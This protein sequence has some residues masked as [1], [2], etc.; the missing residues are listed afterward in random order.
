[1]ENRTRFSIGYYL[2]VF[3]TILMIQSLFFSGHEVKEKTYSDFL[4]DVDEGKVEEVVITPEK[5]YGLMKSSEEQ[6]GGKQV[7]E[8]VNP[9]EKSTP[10]RLPGAK[11][12]SHWLDGAEEQM[13][14]QRAEAARHFT[15]IRVD[16]D[17]LVERLQ[18]HDV[19]FEGKIESKF[20][21]NLFFNW[22]IPFGILMLI[23]GFLMR[24]MRGGPNVLAVGQNKAKIVELDPESRVTF[25]DVAG[26]D[27]PIEETRELVQFLKEPARFQQLGGR[28]PRGVLLAGPPGTGK[29]LLAKAV[30]GEAGVPFYSISGSDF[31]EMFVGVGAAR[32]RDLFAEARK[33]AP[34]IIFIDELDAIGKARGQMGP[35]VGGHDERENTLNQLLVEMDGFDARTAVIILAATNRPE[36]LD[37]AL[38]R[39]GRFDRQIICDRPDLRGRE[40]I[41]QVHLRGMPLAD[42]VDP[43]ALAARTPGFVGADIANLCNEAAL[44]AS[45]RGHQ[46]IH[47]E[48]FAE[49]VERIVAGLERKSRIISDKERRIVAYHESGHALIGHF[50]PSA[51]PV[52]KVSIIPRGRAALGYTLQT[53]LEDRYLMSKEELIGRIRVLLGGRA[54]EEVVFGEVSTGASDDL[55]KASGIV[56]Q[57]LTIYGMSEKLPNLSLSEG[58]QQ[59]YLGQGPRLA[60]HSVGIA[61]AL[62]EEMME[63]L[64]AAY[65]HDL[66]FLRERRDAL[67][68]MA[69][70]LLATETLEAADVVEILGPAPTS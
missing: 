35:M 70:K 24:R 47:M 53:P 45:R 33:Q 28:L 37:P 27:E 59:S 40:G 29:T 1:M 10:W 20:L 60:S 48:D 50:T 36:V 49:A 38:L 21:R 67:E 64:G 14:E 7:D 46:Q 16:D 62:D 18:R 34:C 69:Q 61:E 4:K 41:F 57:M 56:R 66:A 39:A 65:Q 63:I 6:A 54:A 31:V 52:Q 11:M 43:S 30:A 51:D 17:E 32:V 3:A 8:K 13:A 22:I 23:W 26:L 68:A 25:D 9:P 58:N 44:L 5:L 55:E 15:V 2:F 12:I 42:D 19:Q